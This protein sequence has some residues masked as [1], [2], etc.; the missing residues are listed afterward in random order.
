MFSSMQNT[1]LFVS[2]LVKHKLFHRCTCKMRT[3]LLGV[4]ELDEEQAEHEG[5]GHE[6]GEEVEDDH[7]VRLD[8]PTELEL[9][10]AELGDTFF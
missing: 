7:V 10:P 1:I 4:L 6:A 8:L 9:E 5:G 2:V 3:F